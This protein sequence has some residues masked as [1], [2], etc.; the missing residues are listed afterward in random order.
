MTFGSLSPSLCV[1]W[2]PPRV[3]KQQNFLPIT[4]KPCSVYTLIGP[5][6]HSH[7]FLPSPKAAQQPRWPQTGT[8]IDTTCVCIPQFHI[9]DERPKKAHPC[10]YDVGV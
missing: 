1:S 2:F 10:V 3:G 6:F 8:P 5:S 9:Y 4:P 7:R